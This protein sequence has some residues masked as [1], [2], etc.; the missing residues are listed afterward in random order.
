[1]NTSLVMEKGVKLPTRPGYGNR[2][3][4]MKYPLESLEPGDSFFLPDDGTH[5]LVSAQ[6]QTS[7]YNKRFKGFRV[8]GTMTV[9]EHGKP[10]NGLR[11]FRTK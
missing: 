3:G 1:M 9:D 11:V 10:L 2:A 7:K 8:Y 6:V 5:N 4:R